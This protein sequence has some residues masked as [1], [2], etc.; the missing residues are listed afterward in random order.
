MIRR[1]KIFSK[2]D[3][4]EKVEPENLEIECKTQYEVFLSYQRVFISST[5]VY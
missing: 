4:Q 2:N 3:F 5:F 1:N